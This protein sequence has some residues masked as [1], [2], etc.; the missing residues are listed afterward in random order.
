ML[1]F[2]TN[3]FR[4]ECLGLVRSGMALSIKDVNARDL[5]LQREIEEA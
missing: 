5:E 1:D 4:T 2:T 3:G